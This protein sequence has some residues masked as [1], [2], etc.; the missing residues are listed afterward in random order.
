M[1]L[2]DFIV[3]LVLTLCY[4]ILL[5]AWCYNWYDES[6]LFIYCLHLFFNFYRYSHKSLN[7]Q[8]IPLYKFIG[9][10]N[11]LQ[12]CVAIVL[13]VYFGVNIDQNSDGAFT[14]S[15]IGVILRYSLFIYYYF[16]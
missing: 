10:T 14:I 8:S 13:V 1:E 2:V 12:F 15:V 3:C 6:S 9:A 16:I 5:T 4:A 7:I 11:T